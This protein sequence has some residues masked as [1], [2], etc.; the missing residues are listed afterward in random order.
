MRQQ[1]CYLILRQPILPELELIGSGVDIF[2]HWKE[3]TMSGF[4]ESKGGANVRANK[5]RRKRN[6]VESDRCG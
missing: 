1:D 3:I 2:Y 5:E 4:G 6:R